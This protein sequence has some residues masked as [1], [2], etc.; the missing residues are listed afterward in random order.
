[1]NSVRVRFA[2][3]PTG[4]LHIGGARTALFNWLWARQRGGTF[5]LRIEDTDQERSTRGERSSDLRLD[6]LARARLGR[7]PERRRHARPVL[8]D[9]SGSTST[10]STPSG[11]IAARRRLSLLLHE[12]G[13]RRARAPS[14]RSAPAASTASAIRAPAATAATS[15]T[16]RTSCG[17][18]RP[19]AGPSAG[20]I[21]SRAELDVPNDEPAG[22]R[23]DPHRRRAALQPRR[24]R[25]R[26]H[27]GHH[28][29]RARPTITC[30]HAAAD[31]ALRGA[32]RADPAVR[33]PAD[34]PRRRT[35]R[36]SASATAR[37]R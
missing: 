24:R 29:R 2:P 15:P 22:R 9:A 10:A 30:E 8:P 14:T 32:R 11:C 21:W 26:H 20:T 13:A 18:A 3:S 27:D 23:A 37:W 7:G 6:A 31:L 35:A 12:G 36:R 4:Y 33:A 5:V 28:A 25:R 34:D 16:C 17:C 19:R 1:M